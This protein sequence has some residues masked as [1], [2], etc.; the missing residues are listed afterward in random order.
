M[1]PRQALTYLRQTAPENP[2]IPQDL[3]N[4]TADL[5]REI[6]AGNSPTKALIRHLNT[7]RI[8]HRVRVNEDSSRLKCEGL[9]PR[10][11]R[12]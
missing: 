2:V 4:R 7:S 8:Y 12:D 1:P 6:R 10:D 11:T 9:T 5:R 3:Y